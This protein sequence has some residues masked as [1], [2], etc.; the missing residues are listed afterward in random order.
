MLGHLHI[1]LILSFLCDTKAVAGQIAG[2]RYS[3]SL[4]VLIKVI[5]IKHIYFGMNLL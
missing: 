5:R 4:G 2:T 3:H 1:E